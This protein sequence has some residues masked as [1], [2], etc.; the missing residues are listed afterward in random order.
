M[1]ALLTSRPKSRVA[2]ILAHLAPAANLMGHDIPDDDRAGALITHTAIL[3]ATADIFTLSPRH[4]VSVPG[5]NPDTDSHWK[6][7]HNAPVKTTRDVDFFLHLTRP[8]STA[9][10]QVK[11]LQPILETG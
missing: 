9:N 7:L 4:E 5:A 2:V 10:W 11:S 3:A 1:E 8:H 6:L